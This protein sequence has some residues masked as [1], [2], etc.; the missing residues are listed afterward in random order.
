MIVC[1]L[2]GLHSLN[3]HWTAHVSSTGDTVMNMADRISGLKTGYWD[4]VHKGLT[5]MVLK[6]GGLV[7]FIVPEFEGT[8]KSL[9]ENRPKK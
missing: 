6:E 3:S 9:W 5:I 7:P 1:D 8:S 4:R 2:V